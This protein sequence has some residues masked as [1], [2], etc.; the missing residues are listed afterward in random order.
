MDVTVAP[1]QA[2]TPRIALDARNVVGMG[3]AVGAGGG[4]GDHAHETR[5][6]A[7]PTSRGMRPGYESAGVRPR[8]AARPGAI[9]PRAYSAVIAF[10]SAS[11]LPSTPARKFVPDF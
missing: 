1:V 11:K 4:T 5:R 6:S 8:E 2:D 7:R 9:V 3:A 10:P